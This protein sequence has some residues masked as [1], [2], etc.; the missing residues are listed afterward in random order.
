MLGFKGVLLDDYDF[1][2][3]KEDLNSPK[4]NIVNEIDENI[5]VRMNLQELLGS[6]VKFLKIASEQKIPIGSFSEGGLNRLNNIPRKG[7]YGI[8]PLN[9]LFI[10]DLDVNHSQEKSSSLKKHI[11]FF[12]KFFEIN[13][14]ESLAVMTPTG[15]VHIYLS[16][17]WNVKSSIMPEIPK[18]SLRAYSEAFSEVLNEEINIDGDIRTG[19]SNGYVVG[20]TSKININSLNSDPYYSRNTK[21]D[22]KEYYIAGSKDGFLESKTSDLIK[23][24]TISPQAVRKLNRV[25]LIKKKKDLEK[26]KEKYTNNIE[27]D[28]IELILKSDEKELIND[29]PPIEILNKINT[30]IDNAGIKAWHIKRAFTKS[31]L[32]C[33]YSDLAI[34]KACV[35]LKYNRDTFSGKNVPII[36][37]INDLSRFKPTERF[38]SVYCEKGKQNIRKA[39]ISNNV[40][41]NDYDLEKRLK[42]IKVKVSDRSFSKIPDKYRRKRDPRVLDLERIVLALRSS[43]KRE[44]DSQVIKDS[45]AIIEKIFSPLI[46]V[47]AKRVVTSRKFISEE[48]KISN[49]RIGASLRLLRQLNIIILVD[50]QRT[51]MASTYKINDSWTHHKLTKVLRNNWYRKVFKD[52]NISFVFDWR[53]KEFYEVEKNIFY[54]NKYSIEQAIEKEYLDKEYFLKRITYDSSFN[55]RKLKEILLPDE[56][57]NSISRN[58]AFRYLEKNFKNNSIEELKESNITSDKYDFDEILEEL[59]T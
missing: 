31:A 51:G 9:N 39:F 40:K 43:G 13:L 29:L 49:S 10:L 58:I 5:E 23:P 30:N 22:I 17:P 52:P 55:S 44:K 11:D 33:C 59:S 8:I 7:N 19:I 35:Q 57:V 38:H 37:I 4:N 16:F 18:A 50:K 2:S 27:I 21:K 14:Y 56:N 1:I 45:F 28:G 41:K 24:L 53:K 47:G 42:E 3:D 34:A 54:G 36:T 12:S 25:I 15:G 6:N 20:P 48:L 46:N 32:H 26:R